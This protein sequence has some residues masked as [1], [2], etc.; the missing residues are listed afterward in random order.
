MANLQIEKIAQLATEPFLRR[1]RR[2]LL[3]MIAIA[4]VPILAVILYQAKVHRDVQILEVHE[5]AWR[6]TNVIALRQSQVVDAAK[7]LLI[8][9]AQVPVIARGDQGACG[10]VVRG[11]LA[12][13]RAYLDI[14]V[15]EPAGATRCRA[16]DS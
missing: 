14:G 3:L 16:R 9:L 12:Q 13:N 6:L 15:L 2:R 10:E 4:V 11:F 7:Q 8:L 1:L 5:A